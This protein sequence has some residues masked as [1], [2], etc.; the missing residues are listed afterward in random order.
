MVFISQRAKLAPSLIPRRPSILFLPMTNAPLDFL[1][2]EPLVFFLLPDFFLMTVV[3]GSL[4]F[5]TLPLLM[6]L[7]NR[8]FEIH[9][10]VHPCDS[11]LDLAGDQRNV[12]SNG[13]MAQAANHM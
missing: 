1:S 10:P 7:S 12:R 9:H 11:R 13:I 3:C 4:A 6:Q 8:T 2:G 5:L